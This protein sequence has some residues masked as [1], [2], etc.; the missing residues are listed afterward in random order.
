[1]LI[2]DQKSVFK[3]NIKLFILKRQGLKF[4][5][6][7]IDVIYVIAH[8]LGSMLGPGLCENNTT[9]SLLIALAN[10]AGYCMIP[11]FPDRGAALNDELVWN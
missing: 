8:I 1:M 4:G 9:I 2:N 7:R 5:V 11:P 3:S 10:L 6:E